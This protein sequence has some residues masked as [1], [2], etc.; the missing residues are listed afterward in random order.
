MSDA[1][2][3]ESGTE[4]HGG[5]APEVRIT[6]DRSAVR[7]NTADGPVEIRRIQ[8]PDHKIQGE[9]AK[10]SRPAPPAAIQPLVPVAGI[11]PLGKLELIEMLDQPGAIVIV[12]R[13]SELYPHG[14]IPGAV[15]I[16]FHRDGRTAGPTGMQTHRKRVGLFIGQT[17]RPV[18][19]RCLVWSV[20]HRDPAHGR[21]RVSARADPLLS[22][23]HAG[24]APAW[25]DGTKAARRHERLTYAT[26]RR[27]L[28][29]PGSRRNH[30]IPLTKFCLGMDY[31]E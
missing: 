3:H 25:A 1:R 2:L 19:Q 10:T 31:G 27:W 24:L 5:H 11:V 15:N 14:T 29:E 13:K 23:R 8:D 17:G 7:V 20:A 22:Q 26:R 12:S 21:G 9:W 4:L 30:R 18:L 28:A 16:P 6:A